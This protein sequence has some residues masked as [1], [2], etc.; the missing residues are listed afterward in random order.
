[1]AWCAHRMNGCARVGAVC[2][3]QH[4][5]W[6]PVLGRTTPRDIFFLLS[7]TCLFLYL[8]CERLVVVII[9]SFSFLF[10]VIDSVFQSYVLDFVSGSQIS[11]SSELNSPHLCLDHN[12][13][14]IL[15]F[16]HRS[17]CIASMKT[18]VTPPTNS[19][20]R[21]LIV[22][23]FRDPWVGSFHW[24][25]NHRARSHAAPF[26]GVRD[27]QERLHSSIECFI[28]KCQWINNIHYIIYICT[29]YISMICQ[30]HDIVPEQHVLVHSY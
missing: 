16:L 19:P 28:H 29:S 9:C 2:P 3:G 10:V 30:W 5:H 14:S 1:M 18:V 17:F 13:F 25:R 26:I 21:V 15:F 8:L 20:H 4:R 22:S 27:Q 24:L 23:V 7:G 6:C 11:N 12:M